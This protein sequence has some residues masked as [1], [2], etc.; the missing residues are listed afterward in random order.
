VNGPG[1]QGDTI[2][3]A[4][5]CSTEET[6]KLQH[7][8][9][10]VRELYSRYEKQVQRWIDYRNLFVFLGFVA[11]FL[12]VLYLQRN[13]HIAYKV[14]STIES[15][16]LPESDTMQDTDSVYGWLQQLLQART[17]APPRTMLA[18][19]TNCTDADGL[20]RPCVW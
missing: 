4:P 9:E 13:A 17:G 12:A 19:F 14:H 7:A 3:A 20:A 15:V 6:Q 8:Q 5:A 11:L 16:V 2:P 1:T 18:P 10:I